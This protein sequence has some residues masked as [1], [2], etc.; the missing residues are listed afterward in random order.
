MKYLVEFMEKAVVRRRIQCEVTADSEEEVAGLIEN[1][2]YEF[3][4]SWDDDDEGSQFMGIE[5][6]EE[7]PDE[8]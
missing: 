1:G 7:I 8:D 6:I 2:D 5:T 3:I 4:D